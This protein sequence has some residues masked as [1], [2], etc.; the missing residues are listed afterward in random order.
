MAVRLHRFIGSDFDY[1]RYLERE[2]HRY[3][4]HYA[5]CENAVG[6]GDTPSLQLSSAPD[7]TPTP[8]VIAGTPHGSFIKR[9]EFQ[10][11]EYS[12]L[13]T[14]KKARPCKPTPR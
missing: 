6:F 8:I 11:V 12:P 14:P 4:L 1:I 13:T 7:P 9:Q 2:L 10:F 5:S 3:K